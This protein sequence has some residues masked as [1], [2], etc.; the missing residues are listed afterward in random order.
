MTLTQVQADQIAALLNLQNE[1]T[2]QYTRKR[3]LD[4]AEN[5]LIETSD[6][7]DVLA[8]VEVKKVQWYQSE[9]SHLSVSRSA[10]RKGHATAL[11]KQAEQRSRVNGVSLL[12]CTIR[13]GNNVS[14]RLFESLGFLQV[15]MFMNMESGKNLVIYQKVL[16][17]A[18]QDAEKLNS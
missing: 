17:A 15:G 4:H 9:I 7:G 6:Q 10:V 13:E 12:Q 5:Y 18:H 8:C 11:L 2:L 14:R 1:L 3:V 16:S